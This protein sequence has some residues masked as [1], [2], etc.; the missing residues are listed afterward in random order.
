M[1]RV[2]RAAVIYLAVIPG[3][4]F[5]RSFGRTFRAIKWSGV[6]KE[7]AGWRGVGDYLLSVR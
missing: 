6:E 4:C 1:V 7:V 5:T 2:V 3:F